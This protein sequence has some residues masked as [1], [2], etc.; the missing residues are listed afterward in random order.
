MEGLADK[1]ILVVGASSGIGREIA[2]IAVA[3]GARV[4]FAARRLALLTEAVADA[5][6]GLPL[7]CDVRDPSSCAE[8]VRA[9]VDSLGGLDALVYSSAM[10]P[11]VKVGDATPRLWADIMAT[12]VIGAS[13]VVRAAQPHLSATSGRVVLISASSTGRPVPGLGVYA[14][15]KAALEELV[16]V[17]R[18][19]YPEIGF[20]SARVG[21]TLG[22]EVGKDADPDI[23][24]DMGERYLRGGHDLDNGPGTMTVTECA[25][26]V[27]AA[28]TVPVCLREFTATAS[29]EGRAARVGA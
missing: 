28:L 23:R 18:S 29:P 27:L 25:S 8:V 1:R 11:F 5:G 20:T 7:E 6:G 24:K 15:T 19:E 3:S 13:L 16:R 17:W 14:C 21:S 10:V 26:S 2:R 22:T 4:V 9:S 12:N